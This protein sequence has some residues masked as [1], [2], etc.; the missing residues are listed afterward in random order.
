MTVAWH[1]VPGNFHHRCAVPSGRLIAPLVPRIFCVEFYVLRCERRQLEMNI[2]SGAADAFS[3][4]PNRENKTRPLPATPSPGAGKPG[5]TTGSIVPFGTVRSFLFSQALR[6][7]LLSL[8]SLPPSS[9][10]SMEDEAA[11][12][13]RRTGWDK[14]VPTKFTVRL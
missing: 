4:Q 9:R 6:A 7:R 8:E 12:R 13:L 10:H 2:I 3:R 14:F 11:S 1:E 5:A